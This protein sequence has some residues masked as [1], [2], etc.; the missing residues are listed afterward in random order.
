MWFKKTKC[1]A[2]GKT[3]YFT[4]PRTI[5]PKLAPKGLLTSLTSQE[6]LCLSCYKI[7]KKR[8]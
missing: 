7:A 5:T 3:K 6:P 2:C 1:G 4:K 8:L